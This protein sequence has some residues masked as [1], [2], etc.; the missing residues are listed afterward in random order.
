MGKAQ[1][2][3]IVFMGTPEFAIPSL[4]ILLEN[5]LNVVGVVTAPDRPA[6]RGLQIRES[7]VKRFA[8]VKGLP[9]LQPS[10]LKTPGFL[11]EL[12]SLQP[13]LQVVVAFR[14]L[15]EVVW[16][17][18][19]KGTFNLHAS[20]LPQY[21]GAAPINWALI[22][23][24]RETG[25]TTFLLRQKVDTGQL[26]FQQKVPITE[27]DT[28][29][30]LHDK[31]MLGGAKLV[32]KT[33]EAIAADSYE[34]TPQPEISDLKPA[35]KIFKAACEIKWNRNCEALYNFIRGLSPYPTAWTTLNGKT[36][37]IYRAEKSVASHSEPLG[38]ITTDE[39]TYLRVATANGYLDLTEVQ[40]EG[41]KRMTVA[42]LLRGF[43]EKLNGVQLGG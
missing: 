26:I 41:K 15:P 32:L 13:D 42:P 18:P 7:A 39:T 34:L 25:V 38:T 30:S 36:L 28:A 43:R 35:P 37:K 33:V 14:I 40:L 17:M 24:E 29:G 6:G 21:R 16:G 22:N 20:L 9:I 10:K 8:K 2:L 23:G 1:Q 5:Q 3:R 27:R 12:K 31:L 4:A 19:S 11:E